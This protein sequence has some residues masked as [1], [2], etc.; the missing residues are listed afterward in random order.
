MKELTQ[1]TIIQALADLTC[2]SVILYLEFDVSPVKIVVAYYLT[3]VVCFAAY[4]N[5]G[6]L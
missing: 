5:L 1:T 4:R 2:L 3:K 6:K